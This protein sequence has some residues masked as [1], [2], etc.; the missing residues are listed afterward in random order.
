MNVYKEIEIDEKDF[1]WVYTDTSAHQK[2]GT[3]S[4][5]DIFIEDDET[6]EIYF[7]VDQYW[8]RDEERGIIIDDKGER[9]LFNEPDEALMYIAKGKHSLIEIVISKMKTE[10]F[11]SLT[12]EEK[13]L[14]KEHNK[15]QKQNNNLKTK[16]NGKS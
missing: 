12:E 2:W 13:V 14:L 8:I 11:Q 6:G 1:C 5:L 9:K 3:I 15:K 4:K 16:N 10:G 7:T